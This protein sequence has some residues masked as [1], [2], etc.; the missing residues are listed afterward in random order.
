MT[1]C[2]CGRHDQRYFVHVLF[3]SEIFIHAGSESVINTRNVA[4]LSSQTESGF[5]HWLIHGVRESGLPHDLW[6]ETSSY[7]VFHYIQMAVLC[8]LAK[9]LRTTTIADTFSMKISAGL[10]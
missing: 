5:A 1:V 7:E 6:T 9:K 2:H 3:A 4:T 8:S 10:K